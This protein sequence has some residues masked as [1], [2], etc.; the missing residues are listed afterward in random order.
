MDG[1]I[2][3]EE[4]ACVGA[5]GGG[6]LRWTAFT[7]DAAAVLAAFRA[8]VDDP[9]G[10]ADDVEIV[11]DDDDRIAQI[12]QPV[13]DFEQ[14][15]HVIEMKAGG[16]LVQKVECAAGL[17]LG[18][19]ASQLHA[20]SFA[21]GKRGGALA[22]M[23][24]AEA[25]IDKGLQLLAHLGDVGEDRERVFD[26]E[27]KDVG[28]GVA[29]EFYGESFLVVTAAIADFTL[30][31]YIGHEV[32]LD[33]PLAVTLAGFAAAS[34]DVEA[35][36]AGL[37]AAL[38]RLGQHGKKVADGRED[39]GVG[40]GIGAWRTADGGLVDANDFVDLLGAGQGVVGA[41]FFARAVDGLGQRAI[42]NVVD[43]RAFT[44]AT[45]AGDHGHY[46][47][48]NADCEILEVVLA[49]SGNGEPFAGE[50]T[51]FGALKHG[52]GAGKIAAGQRFGRGHDLFGVPSA[53]TLP[54]RRPAPG[55]RSRT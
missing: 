6:D 37:V 47:E 30:H 13:K 26:G 46:A 29:V 23:H 43:Q 10:V 17:A 4:L 35:E 36:A 51:G 54:P 52:R 44:A 20:L 55:P 22:E 38:A 25:H 45:D 14:L 19:F 27:I 5:G 40:G 12:C 48:R 53:T 2:A 24:I 1:V 34:G 50:G 8:E 28:Y 15:A 18:E 31:V 21:A 11:L 7:H 42:K 16:R 39:L 49:G 9:I 3:H 41:G 32:H 33:A